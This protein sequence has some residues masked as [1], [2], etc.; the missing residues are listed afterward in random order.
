M[1][2]NGGGNMYGAKATR[3]EGSKSVAFLRNPQWGAPAQALVE[4]FP[5]ATGRPAQSHVGAKA[6]TAE[7]CHLKPQGNLVAD[8]TRLCRFCDARD[9]LRAKSIA[10]NYSYPRI[11]E[12]VEDESEPTLIRHG[13]VVEV[14]DDVGMTFCEAAI[15]C[16]TQTRRGLDD[17]AHGE[18]TRHQF[19]IPVARAVIDY[20]NLVC[21]GFEY[22]ESF[23]AFPQESDAIAGA[24]DDG[25]CLVCVLAR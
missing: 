5:G 20:E 8:S 25:G 15:A 1:Q 2:D 4:N 10:G 11:S 22:R 17:I 23:E 21:W 19:S 13:I 6:Q 16:A 3:E 7:C 9:L 24:D 14:G 18:F 12:G